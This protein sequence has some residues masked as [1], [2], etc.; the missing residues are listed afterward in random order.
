ML[1]AGT[2]EI[3]TEKYS[4]TL[5]GKVVELTSKEYELLK[6]LV[7]SNG[8]VLTRE[9]LLEH[10]WGYTRASEIETRTVDMH[11][12]QLRKKIKTEAHRIGTVKNAGYRFEMDDGE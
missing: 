10:V 9:H 11:I 4:V 12:G 3:N 7:E 6:A 1:K 8:R 2:L 5:K